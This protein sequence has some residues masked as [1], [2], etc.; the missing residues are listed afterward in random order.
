MSP[1][2]TNPQLGEA[3]LEVVENQIRENNPP[4]TRQTLARLRKLGYPGKEARRMIA[5]V[6]SVELFHIMRDREEFNR[7]RFLRH[8]AKLPG[9][10]W[11]EDGTS[12]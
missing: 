7:E 1:E 4:E 9:E 12:D 8:L 11:N 10:P 3:I 2:E 5:T 6:V